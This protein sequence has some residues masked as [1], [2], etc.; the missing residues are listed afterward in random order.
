MDGYLA[1]FA[2]AY[3]IPVFILDVD[4][5]VFEDLKVQILTA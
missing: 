1:G 2:R 5:L 4:F 3:G